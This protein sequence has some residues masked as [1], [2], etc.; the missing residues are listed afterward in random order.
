MVVSL[1][2]LILLLYFYLSPKFSLCLQ[3][4]FILNDFKM[5]LTVQ[6]LILHTTTKG[7]KKCFQLSYDT[8]P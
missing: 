6:H 5:P 2:F 8:K 1:Q 4:V 3:E 7:K